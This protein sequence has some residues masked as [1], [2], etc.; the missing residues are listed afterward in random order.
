MLALGRILLLIVQEIGLMVFLEGQ[1]L[2][3]WLLLVLDLLLLGLEGLL[4]GCNGGRVLM[5]VLG[6]CCL[7]NQARSRVGL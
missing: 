2:F 5:S 4:G 6:F 7:V 1:G 3:G